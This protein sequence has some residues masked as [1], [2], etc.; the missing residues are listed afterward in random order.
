MGL[1]EVIWSYNGDNLWLNESFEFLT[2]VGLRTPL[3]RDFISHRDAFQVKYINVMV[4]VYH[5]YDVQ[6]N[7]IG[8]YQH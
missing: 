4:M 2:T 3:R 8:N 6:A 7:I 1:S 5:V